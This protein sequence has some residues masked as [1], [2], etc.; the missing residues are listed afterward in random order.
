MQGFNDIRGTLFFDI[1][2]IPKHK[3][4][5]AFVLENVK[6]LVGHYKGRTLK[7]II[8]TLQKLGYHVQYA[9]L[10]ALDYAL[11]QKRETVIIV[12]HRPP[13]IFPFPSPFIPYNTV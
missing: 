1:A 12:G 13:S 3:R 9:A 4:P 10:N 7:I 2:R 11:P 5:K 6:Q 8:K